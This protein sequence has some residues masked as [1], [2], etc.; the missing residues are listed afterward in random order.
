MDYR[1]LTETLKSVPVAWVY[2]YRRKLMN[3]VRLGT[4]DMVPIPGRT[5]LKRHDRNGQEVDWEVQEHLIADTEAFRTWHANQLAAYEANRSVSATMR[6]LVTLE[7][8]I[9]SGEVKFEELAKTYR[10]RL[11]PKPRGRRGKAGKPRPERTKVGKAES[12]QESALP[13]SEL[14]VVANA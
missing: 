5:T 14:E 2:T 12:E 6:G 9:T 7:E 1:K 11:N 13:S 8:A 4:V 3:A 10:E